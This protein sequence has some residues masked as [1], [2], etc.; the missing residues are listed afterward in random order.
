MRGIL[1]ILLFILLF[2]IVGIYYGL[3]YGL[4]DLI[5]YYKNDIFITKYVAIAMFRVIIAPILMFIVWAVVSVVI[6]ES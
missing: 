4:V 2:L 5:T 1:I 6:I 3:I